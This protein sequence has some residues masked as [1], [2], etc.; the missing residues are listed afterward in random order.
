MVASMGH[1]CRR[2]HGAWQCVPYV[3]GFGLPFSSA[4]GDPASAA[5]A[6]AALAASALAPA[7]LTAALAAAAASSV[8]HRRRI[9]LHWGGDLVLD[10]HVA[11]RARGRG[12]RFHVLRVGLPHADRIS[13]GSR[14]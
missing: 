7:A 5:L 8:R 14:H 1:W 4:A 13:L 9:L 3:Y 2:Q 11:H 12:A 10:G 6:A